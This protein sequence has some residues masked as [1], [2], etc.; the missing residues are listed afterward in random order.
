MKNVT[1]FVLDASAVLAVVFAEA[2]AN[3]V[4]PR[5]PGG[6]LSTVNLSEVTTQAL[7]RGRPLEET[8]HDLERLPMEI[9]PFDAEQA[10]VAAS[11]LKAT[12]KSGLSLGDRACLALGL[13]RRMPVIT[14]DRKWQGLDV[15]VTIKVFR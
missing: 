15:G 14:G 2:G 6:L 9:V 11:L 7:R 8:I 5:L 13:V 4:I 12:H 10:H 3:A 1:K